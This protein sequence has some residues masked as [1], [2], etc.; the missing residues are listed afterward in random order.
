MPALIR[1]VPIDPISGEGAQELSAQAQLA[2]QHLHRLL[3]PN[4][5]AGLGLEDGNVRSPR[6]AVHFV[7]VTSPEEKSTLGF[8]CI[9]PKCESH[10]S[11]KFSQ[12]RDTACSTLY[13]NILGIL[14]K[15]RKEPSQLITLFHF[16][17]THEAN[18]IE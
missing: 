8:W 2:F 4:F 16:V 6:P 3:E 18:W 1:K 14:G 5:Q 15:H 11:T 7:A 12:V 9:P 17:V 10:G 13:Y